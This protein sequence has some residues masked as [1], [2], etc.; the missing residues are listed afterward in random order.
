[1]NNQDLIDMGF[2]VIPHFTVTDAV[3][4]DLGRR[5]ILSAGAMGTANEMLWICELDEEDDME[6]TDLICL[7]NYDYDGYIT[8]KKLKSLI[9]IITGEDRL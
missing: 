9:N 4:Y 6:I 1:M 7:H 3:T 5:R 2:K 8:E